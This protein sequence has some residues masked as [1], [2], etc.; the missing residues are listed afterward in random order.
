L[1]SWRRR[2]IH[3]VQL[4]SLGDSVSRATQLL[5]ALQ[6]D[7]LL[8]GTQTHILLLLSRRV[9]CRRGKR[10][11]RQARAPSLR[12]T[13]RVIR[14]KRSLVVASADGLP[15]GSQT[16]FF[17]LALGFTSADLIGDSSFCLG[18][19]LYGA[20]GGGTSLAEHS[21]WTKHSVASGSSAWRSIRLRWSARRRNITQRR[22]RGS[23]LVEHLAWCRA[24]DDLRCHSR[25]GAWKCAGDGGAGRRRA[26]GWSAE[27]CRRGA[28][29]GATRHRHGHEETCAE[30]HGT[31]AGDEGSTTVSTKKSRVDLDP[32]P[33]ELP[34]KRC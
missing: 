20:L 27:R 29:R 32:D 1:N 26:C 5:W 7:S 10:G 3:W 19:R 33:E 11:T 28:V 9:F 23:N 21:A 2:N 25:R 22:A 18:I 6:A 15:S 17:F 8:S 24:C 30:Q 34:L 4:L 14:G 16:H 31:D 13:H 12:V